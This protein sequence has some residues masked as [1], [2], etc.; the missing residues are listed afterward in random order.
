MR[1][2][3]RR[4]QRLLTARRLLRDMGDPC[5]LRHADRTA[6]GR[7]LARDQTQKRGLARAVA[8]DE[9]NLVTFRYG[10]RCVL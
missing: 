6:I 5:I 3:H 1:R 8:P 7:N 10:G 4:K 9:T 2:E